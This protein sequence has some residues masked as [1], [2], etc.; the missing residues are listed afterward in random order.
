M[1]KQAFRKNK[2]ECLCDLKVGKDFLDKSQKA[3]AIKREKINT[4]DFIKIRKT[5]WAKAFVMK[6][7]M[8]TKDLEKLDDGLV[9][10]IYKN[11]KL[12]IKRQ[13]DF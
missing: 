4:L 7:Q 8:Q 10:R 6:I 3:T 5:G 13:P 12:A 9:S 2:G 1:K 11:Y